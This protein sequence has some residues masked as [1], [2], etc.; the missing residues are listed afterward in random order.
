M[1]ALVVYESLWGNT[2]AIAHAIGEGIGHDTTV[3]HT[4][5]I[6]PAAASDFDLIVVGAPVHALS[7]PTMESKASAAGRPV[8]EDELA[9]DVSQPAVKDW[10][11]GMPAGT[12]AAAAFDTRIR[13]P[14]GHGGASRIEK[15]L[16][17]NGYRIVDKAQGFTVVNEAHVR[18]A[19][20]MLRQGERKRAQE[21][22]EKLA[23]LL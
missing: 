18:A 2:A 12:A 5:E 16:K 15:A 22:G 3:A 8:A 1:E 13:G 6:D 17:A 20:S 11:A 19:G 23:S 21:W 9:P 4:G 7:L 14:L 10:L